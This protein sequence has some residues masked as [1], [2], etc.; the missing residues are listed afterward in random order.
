[1]ALD[2]G[3]MLKKYHFALFLNGG[4]DSVISWLQ[5]RKSTDNTITGNPE[6]QTF[7]YIV[8]ESPT[9]EVSRYAPTLSQPITMYKGDPSF[10]YVWEKFYNQAVGADAHSDILVVFYG[11]DEGEAYKAWKASCILT[12]DNLNPVESVITATITFNGTTEKGTAV[13]TDG[14]PVF[15][16]DST[17]E[18]AMTFTAEN[19]AADPIVGA[20]ITIDGVEKTTNDDGEAVFYLIDKETYTVGAYSEGLTYAEVFVADDA[21]VADT[22]TLV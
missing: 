19:A 9:T 1:M 14:V 21:V 4:T 8:D 15:T 20:T 12:I 3:T 16:G 7:D 10:E 5:I 17:T 18:F 22:L 13:V 2:L 6:T 11:A